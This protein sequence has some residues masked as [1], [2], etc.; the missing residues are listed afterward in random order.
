MTFWEQKVY[1]IGEENRSTV[2]QQILHSKASN[3]VA[4]IKLKINACNT[5]TAW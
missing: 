1:V 3:Y 5:E 4:Y 2:C